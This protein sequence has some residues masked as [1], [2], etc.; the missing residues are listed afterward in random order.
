VIGP[1]AMHETNSYGE[2]VEAAGTDGRF[3]T[4]TSIDQIRASGGY[5]IL[6]PD[7]CVVMAKSMPA[8]SLHPLMGGLDPEFGWKGVK[9]FVEKVLPRL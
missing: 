3:A 7:E 9:L 4:V 2:W 5:L 1:H 6:T 8:V